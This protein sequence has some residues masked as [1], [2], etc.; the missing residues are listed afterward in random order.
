MMAISAAGVIFRCGLY[1]VGPDTIAPHRTDWLIYTLPVVP[2]GMFRYVFLLHHRGGEDPAWTL[3][4]D[5]H[6]LVGD[7]LWLG[8]ALW[9]IR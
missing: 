2:Y 8:V 7:T 4:T 6:M 9:R 5:A 3:V 1:S